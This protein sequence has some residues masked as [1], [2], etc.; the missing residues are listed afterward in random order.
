MA[1]TACPATRGVARMTELEANR[2][3][4]ADSLTMRARIRG[5]D[6]PEEARLFA[7]FAD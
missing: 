3:I 4:N 1:A 6:E 7:A 5:V 2:V